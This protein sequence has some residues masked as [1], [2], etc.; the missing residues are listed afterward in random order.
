MP[1]RRRPPNKTQ[2]VAR[3]RLTHAAATGSPVERLEDHEERAV[4]SGERGRHAVV[5][6]GVGFAIVTGRQLA[7]GVEEL[8][9][10]RAT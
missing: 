9:V 3:G 1:S 8:L 2:G 5:R 7:V 4:P 10:E 6:N